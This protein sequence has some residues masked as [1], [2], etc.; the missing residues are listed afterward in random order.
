MAGAGILPAEYP[1]TYGA[2]V[3]GKVTVNGYDMSDQR[4]KANEGSFGLFSTCP[5]GPR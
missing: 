2:G 5:R 1:A 3:P 4:S